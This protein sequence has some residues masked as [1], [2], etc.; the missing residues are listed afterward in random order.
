MEIGIE[1][2]AR[3]KIYLHPQITDGNHQS[4]YLISIKAFSFGIKQLD[5]KI[6][7]PSDV[8][9]KNVS[10]YISNFLRTSAAQLN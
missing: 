1:L 8:K 3:N 7:I 10:R 4:A 5:D 9:F 6:S 2:P